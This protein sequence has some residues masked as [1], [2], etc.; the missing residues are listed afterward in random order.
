MAGPFLRPLVGGAEA[1][2][3]VGA[4]LRPLYDEME[5][6]TCVRRGRNY[7]IMRPLNYQLLRPLNCFPDSSLKSDNTEESEML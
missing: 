3:F 1:S 7:L 6:S 4:G 2:V 5:A